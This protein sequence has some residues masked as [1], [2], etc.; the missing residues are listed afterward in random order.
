MIEEATSTAVQILLRERERK[1][2]EIEQIDIALAALG[3]NPVALATL[4]SASPRPA[5]RPPARHQ[6]EI[7]RLE[8]RVPSTEERW[9]DSAKGKAWRPTTRGNDRVRLSK[10]DLD[11]AILAF[12]RETQGRPFVRLAEVAERLEAQGLR[13]PGRDRRNWYAGVGQVLQ[14]MQAERRIRRVE[15][16]KGAYTVLRRSPGVEIAAANGK[17]RNRRAHARGARVKSPSDNAT[18]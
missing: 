12:L 7:E 1:V 16:F 8:P 4:A 2:K 18:S 11:D 5:K 17:P 9:S 6:L 15:G 14:R 3:A 13:R 10:G